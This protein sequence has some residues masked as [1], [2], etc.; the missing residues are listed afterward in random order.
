MAIVLFKTS[1]C[2]SEDP[3]FSH[4]VT[5]GKSLEPPRLPFSNK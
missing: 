5:F 3:G 2:S 1:K 4:R